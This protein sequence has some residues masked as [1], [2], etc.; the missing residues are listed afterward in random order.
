[1]VR[2]ISKAQSHRATK[3]FR[4]LAENFQVFPLLGVWRPK[5]YNPKPHFK[6]KP[7]SCPW[8]CLSVLASVMPWFKTDGISMAHTCNFA[9]G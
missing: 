7:K 1:M 3:A 9:H 8:E 6:E 5:P 4:A 2:Y